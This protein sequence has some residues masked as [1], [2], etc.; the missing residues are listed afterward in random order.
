MSKNSSKNRKL[1]QKNSKKRKSNA[2]I[3]NLQQQ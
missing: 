2:L 1:S 3:E